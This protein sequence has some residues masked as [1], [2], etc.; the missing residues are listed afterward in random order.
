MQIEPQA[1]KYGFDAVKA[2][3]DAVRSLADMMKGDPAKKKAAE[4]AILA[5]DMQ[6]KFAEAQLA[7]VLG[8]ELC[9]AHFPPIPML[10][11]RV[12]EEYVEV[13]YRCPDCGMEEPSSEFF[14]QKMR[15]DAAFDARNQELNN[16][17]W[18]AV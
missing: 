11:S 4:A 8:Y 3:L 2:A 16:V 9:R 1:I 14:A 10:K 15:I 18:M 17:G 6:L 12:H 13:I 7:Q 5:A